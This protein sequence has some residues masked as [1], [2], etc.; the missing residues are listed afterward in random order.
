MAPLAAGLA[1][2]GRGDD[3]DEPLPLRLPLPL[4]SMDSKST[5][6]VGAGLARGDAV[7]SF[8]SSI[9]IDGSGVAGVAATFAFALV[10]F[11]V[12]G[13]ASLPRNLLKSSSISETAAAVVAAG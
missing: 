4:P 5:A 11:G 12:L 13:L 3:D 6:L 7:E 1:G 8:C 2:S 10:V 9:C